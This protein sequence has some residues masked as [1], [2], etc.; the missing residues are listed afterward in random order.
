MEVYKNFR[1]A[2]RNRIAKIQRQN[3]PK[4]PRRLSGEMRVMRR[5]Q[6]RLE[7]SLEK[8]AVSLSNRR[9]LGRSP[10]QSGCNKF[11]SLSANSESERRQSAEQPL[12]R[13]SCHGGLEYIN[14]SIMSCTADLKM[15]PET[16][17]DV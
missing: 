4:T 16:K 7:K 12:V 6:V 10:S 1:P 17:H 11:R 15:I 13:I 2:T 8:L 14:P 9:L 5:S 3:N